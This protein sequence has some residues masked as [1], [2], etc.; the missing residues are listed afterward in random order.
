MGVRRVVGPSTRVAC[1]VRVVVEFVAIATGIALLRTAT[2]LRTAGG[3]V[4]T[5]KS[6]A[7]ASLLSMMSSY[8]GDV[9]VE[10]VDDSRAIEVDEALIL[11]G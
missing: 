1:N 7:V 6:C 9:V 4:G 10:D 8:V 11:V 2:S 3:G 5:A